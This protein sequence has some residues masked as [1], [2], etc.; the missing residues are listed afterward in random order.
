MG[1]STFSEYIVVS[2]F[3][4]AKIDSAAALDKVCLIGCGFSTGYS[5]AVKSA[6]VKGGATCVVFGLVGAG[7]AVVMGCKAAGASGI[8]GIDINEEKFEKAKGF[9][10]AECINPKLHEKPI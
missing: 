1:T 5:A 3:S 4:V 6:K 8:I 9:G 7:L 2:D 10:V